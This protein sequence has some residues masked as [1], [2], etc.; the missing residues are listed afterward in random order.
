MITAKQSGATQRPAPLTKCP[1]SAAVR[2]PRLRGMILPIT[3]PVDPG[4][5]KQAPPYAQKRDETLKKIKFRAV[6]RAGFRI[7]VEFGRAGLQPA[8]GKCMLSAGSRCGRKEKAFFYIQH[9]FLYSMRHL[10]F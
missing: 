9:V 3:E 6:C 4:P 5:G 2:P 8:P 1:A 7:P 10:C